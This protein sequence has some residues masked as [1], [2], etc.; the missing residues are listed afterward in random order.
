M[1]AMQYTGTVNPN[2]LKGTSNEWS[3]WVSNLDMANHKVGFNCA[4]A[5]TNDQDLTLSAEIQLRNNGRDIDT[6]RAE[7]DNI[8]KQVVFA[9]VSVTFGEVRWDPAFFLT[10]ITTALADNKPRFVYSVSRKENV[11]GDYANASAYC[12]KQDFDGLTLSSNLNE[13]SKYFD[14]LFRFRRLKLE[15]GTVATPWCK[16]VDD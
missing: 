6:L 1:F 16:H 14:L 4:E 8:L 5:I 12:E 15:Q 7:H 10:D 2:L 11:K 9:M 3:E 13:N